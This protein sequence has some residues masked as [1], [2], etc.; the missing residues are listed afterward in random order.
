MIGIYK[1]TNKINNKCYIGKSVDIDY[2][3]NRHRR[4]AFRETSSAYNC[5][6]YKAIRHYGLDNFTFE[7]IEECDVEKLDDREKYYI[8]LYNSYYKNGGGYNLTRGGDGA[9][10][11]D[12]QL[13]CDL[14]NDGLTISDIAKKV[15]GSRNTVKNI[16]KICEADYS[17]E[18]A[19]RRGTLKKCIPI[20]RRSMLGEFIDVWPSSKEIERKFGID[21]SSVIDCCNYLVRYAGGY[22][23]RY[24]E[25]SETA[26]LADL[27]DE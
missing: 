26:A 17:E 5:Y 25:R 27:L 10:K 4:D 19:R 15:H 7:V 14:W 11:Q 13:I 24:A 21:H 2:R 20:E 12:Y 6:F 18:E 1:A 22:K 16:L 3:I 23:W 8:K 9:L